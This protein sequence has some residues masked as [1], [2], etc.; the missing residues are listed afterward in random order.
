MTESKRY[1]RDHNLIPLCP[2]CRNDTLQERH[3][4]YGQFFYC[5]SCNKTTNRRQI[6]LKNSD[7]HRGE[8]DFVFSE[9]YG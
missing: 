2:Y 9:V 6:A 7:G 3:G 4:R 5:S 1:D 8:E